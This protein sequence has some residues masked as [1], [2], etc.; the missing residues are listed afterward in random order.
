MV[1]QIEWNLEAEETLESTLIYLQDNYSTS[2]AE[3]FLDEIYK[4]IDKLVK[5]PESGR[6]SAI[7]ASVMIAKIDKYRIMYY[8]FDGT[9]L[10]IHDFFDTRQ[11]P[12]KRKY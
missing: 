8:D 5:N 1:Q 10:T 3:R 9:K 4:I 12:K 6:R 11:D 2:V 7:D